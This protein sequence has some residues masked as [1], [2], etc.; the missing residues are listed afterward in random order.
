LGMSED[1]VIRHLSNPWMRD[2][3]VARL[4]TNIDRF[5]EE[6]GDTPK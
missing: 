1:E 3:E 5:L 2:D 6:L 4:R